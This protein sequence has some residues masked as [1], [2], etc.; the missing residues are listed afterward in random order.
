MNMQQDTGSTLASTLQ[1]EEMH[2]LPEAICVPRQQLAQRGGRRCRRVLR[3]RQR[4]CALHHLLCL[5]GQCNPI[6]QSVSRT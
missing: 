3:R 5:A 1:Q 4:P 6:R 2:L